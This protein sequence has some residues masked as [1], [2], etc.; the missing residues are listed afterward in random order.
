MTAELGLED[1]SRE[2][3]EALASNRFADLPFQ[4]TWMTSMSLL[5]EAAGTL[6]DTSAAA[7]LYKLLLPYADRVAVSR[8]EISTG[9]VARY[10]GLLAAT[11]GRADDAE[12]H[13][14]EAMEL[15]ERIGA[16]SWRTHTQADFGRLA[17]ARGDRARG[18][19]LLGAAHATY[20]E[21]GMS[22]HAVA[23]DEAPRD[24]RLG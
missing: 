5:A 14:V 8:P 18:G 22:A 20:R 9:A 3:L 17:L 2:H 19:R 13:F 10:L 12:R 23:L 7:I 6:R 21:L 4:E 16:R 15:N 24:A 11:I 1:E